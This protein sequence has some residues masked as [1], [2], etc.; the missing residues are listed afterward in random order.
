MSLIYI[1]FSTR[2]KSADLAQ[3][4]T[5]LLLERNQAQRPARRWPS[6]W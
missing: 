5:A 3:A 6:E 1:C 2:I 4:G